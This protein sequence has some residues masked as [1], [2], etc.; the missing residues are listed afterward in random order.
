MSK[1][2]IYRL[3]KNDGG[4]Y[5]HIFI[6]ISHFLTAKKLGFQFYIDDQNWLYSNNKGWNDY[7]TTTDLILDNTS[8]ENIIYI[9][10]NNEITEEKFKIHEF[11]DALID[12]YKIQPNIMY[13]MNNL[14]ENINFKKGDFDAIMIRRGDKMIDESKIISAEEYLIPLIERDTKNIFI[15]TD[16]Y[17]VYLE[18]SSI[19]KN[20]YNNKGIKLFTTCPTNKFGGVGFIRSLDF[21]K[22]NNDQLRNKKYC[23]FMVEKTNIAVDQFNKQQMKS[24]IE[25]MLIGNEICKISRYLT[26]DFQS[27]LTRFLCMTHENISNVINVENNFIPDFNQYYDLMGE[28][29]LNR[30]YYENN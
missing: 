7:F 9:T 10:E 22:N 15:E 23:E 19:I 27:N 6:L 2:Y 13:K 16:D 24:H 25:T 29:F 1:K 18:L 11:R 4:F 14:L 5:N 12:V 28:V 26:T 8:Y 21:I 17:N 3:K 20:K 30:K